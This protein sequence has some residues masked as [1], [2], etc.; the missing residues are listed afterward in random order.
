MQHL[1]NQGRLVHQPARAQDALGELAQ[2]AEMLDRQGDALRYPVAP[3]ARCSGDRCAECG[4]A[5]DEEA[6]GR[7]QL[8][9]PHDAALGWMLCASA[10]YGRTGRRVATCLELLALSQLQIPTNEVPG[11]PYLGRVEGAVWLWKLVQADLRQKDAAAE[12]ACERRRN[13]DLL[14]NCGR[15]VELLEVARNRT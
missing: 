1:A 5:L 15:E 11:N 8:L 7:T 4:A 9:T 12:D 6:G 10:P 2:A 3:C 14:Y 13:L